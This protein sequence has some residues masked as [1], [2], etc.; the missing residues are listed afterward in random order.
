MIPS[1]SRPGPAQATRAPRSPTSRLS[2]RRVVDGVRSCK[3][4]RV[5]GTGP[6]VL[7][8]RRFFLDLLRIV[9]SGCR[10]HVRR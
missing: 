8:V 1:T 9:T 4:D 10:A 2:V 6:G 3:A 5:N 7:L